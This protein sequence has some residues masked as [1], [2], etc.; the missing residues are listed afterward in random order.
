LF[1]TNFCTNGLVAKIR[2]VE[3]MINTEVCIIR[4]VV[5]KLVIIASKAPIANQKTK[6]P[7][8]MISTIKQIPAMINQICH[9]LIS[10]SNSTVIIISH[11]YEKRNRFM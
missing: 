5:K 1:F 6:N 2:I 8:V 4:L 7:T 11:I 10:S 9:I 3:E